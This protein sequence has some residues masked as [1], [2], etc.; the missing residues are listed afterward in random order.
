MHFVVMHFVVLSSTAITLAVCVQI[1]NAQIARWIPMVIPPRE[2]LDPGNGGYLS[3]QPL[4]MRVRGGTEQRKS[5]WRQHAEGKMQTVRNITYVATCPAL[6]NLQVD[7]LLERCWAHTLWANRTS[8]T[9]CLQP[10]SG[11]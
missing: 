7:W 5:L 3:Q 8:R 9:G 4:I 2:W 1:A 6:K 10:A 11:L